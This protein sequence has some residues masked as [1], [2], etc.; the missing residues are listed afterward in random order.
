MGTLEN[1][2]NLFDNQSD[3]FLIVGLDKDE[4]N[5]VVD[6]IIDNVEYKAV[7]V[8]GKKD[9]SPDGKLFIIDLENTASMSYQALL[10]YY[11]ELPLHYNCFICLVSNSSLCLNSFEKRVR[12][13]FKHKIFFI[14]KSKEEE[15]VKNF[16][17]KF[18]FEMFNPM[19]LALIILCHKKKISESNC[20]EMF[21]QM[22]LKA[23]ML[24]SAAEYDILC[25]YYDL[26]ECRI[27]NKAGTVIVDYN[28][29][30]DFISKNAPLY[31]KDLL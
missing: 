1:I 3:Q 9:T 23:N 4:L 28:E 5:E 14:P 21:K 29:F 30:K 7:R 2:L 19:H 12:S 6:K 20:Y 16:S 27:I 10:Y 17:L 24:R 25:C 15:P 18:L 11:L 8:K 22:V 26:L 13:R 31:V